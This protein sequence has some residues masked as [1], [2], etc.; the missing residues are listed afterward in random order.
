MYEVNGQKFDSYFNAIATAK[1]QGADV[2]ETETGI[3]RWTPAAKI[4]SKKIRRYHE[5]K[6]AYE[7]QE[8]A[9]NS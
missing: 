4:S 8:R 2:V 9:K 5:Q 1:I 3:R 6:A 7:A